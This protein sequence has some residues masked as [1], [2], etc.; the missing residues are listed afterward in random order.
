[1]SYINKFGESSVKQKLNR[2]SITKN[3]ISKTN[4]VLS[5]KMNGLRTDIDN[6]SMLHQTD[7][8]QLSLQNDHSIAKIVDDIKN[9][10][11]RID[12]LKVDVENVINS[13]QKHIENTT[14]TLNKTI[15][16]HIING[17]KEYKKNIEDRFN[18]IEEF[19]Y[20][21]VGMEE[22]KNQYTNQLNEIKNDMKVFKEAI[23]NSKQLYTEN[24][25]Y[26]SNL[27][28]RFDNIETYL[29]RTIGM[30]RQN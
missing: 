21:W 14:I 12:K 27:E 1:M 2:N 5:A 9:E 26:L 29:F 25:A 20:K 19:I 16:N 8:K 24:K 7:V 10:S 15:S 17:N 18:K 11:I 22:L 4:N 30:K 6:L 13:I 3:Y 28:Q 23:N